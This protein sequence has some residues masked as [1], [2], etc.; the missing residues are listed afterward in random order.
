MKKLLTCIFLSN[1]CLGAV[2]S[3][4]V[5]VQIRI[6]PIRELSVAEIGEHISAAPIYAGDSFS[7]VAVNSY[8]SVST[9][10][11]A[12]LQGSIACAL[13]E[14]ISLYASSQSG[15]VLLTPVLS[16]LVTNINEGYHPA[17]P[18]KLELDHTIEAKTSKNSIFI[19][20]ELTP[21]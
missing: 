9:N 1:A 21:I 10:M 11:K 2:A 5:S 3:T 19:R 14:G 20:Y 15:A 6:Q 18:I 13:P 17:I 7:N 4:T 8:C 12:Q 16:K